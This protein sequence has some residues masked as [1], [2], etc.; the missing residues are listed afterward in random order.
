MKIILILS[1]TFIIS[2]CVSG[3]KKYIYPDK[4]TDPNYQNQIENK[5]VEMEVA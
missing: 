2:G 5:M 4:N 1:I 3:D